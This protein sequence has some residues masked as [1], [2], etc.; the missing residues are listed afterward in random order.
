MESQKFDPKIFVNGIQGLY[1]NLN[2]SML[3]LIE[4]FARN[5]GDQSTLN[6]CLR[7]FKTLANSLPQN[8]VLL[9]IHRAFGMYCH[10][11]SKPIINA[12]I[13]CSFR[14]KRDSDLKKINKA[15]ELI[16]TLLDPDPSMFNEGYLLN[17]ANE[18]VAKKQFP[19]GLADSDTIALIALME[20][21]GVESGKLAFIKKKTPKR[22]DVVNLFIYSVYCT[23]KYH[24]PKKT[25]NAICSSLASLLTILTGKKHTRQN[26]YGILN[27]MPKPREIPTSAK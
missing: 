11:R 19:G 20:Q 2:P 18:K 5:I 10:F 21:L 17:L 6:K 23:L 25:D 26:V 8:E 4:E 9:I 15:I 3:Q 22:H 24:K 16:K 1:S 27:R 13:K 14:K 12:N 7:D